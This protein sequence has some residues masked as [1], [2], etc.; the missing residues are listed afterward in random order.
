L[1][2]LSQI[3][4]VASAL[5]VFTFFVTMG[6]VLYLLGGTSIGQDLA[7]HSAK[8][9][10][11]AFL[12]LLVTPIRVNALGA[13]IVLFAIYI[14]C[15][16]IAFRSNPGFFKSIRNM[17]GAPTKDPPNW[18]I[19]MPLAASALLLVVVAL[20]I[21][22]D[23]LGVPSGSLPNLAPYELLYD[24]AYA[25]PAEETAFRITTLGLLVTFMVLLTNPLKRVATGTKPPTTRRL[26]L[27]GLLFPE[28]A[29]GEAGLSTVRANGLRGLNTIEW[30]ALIV[31]SVG[32]GIAHYT[33]DVGWQ[34][35]KVATA[36]LSGFALGLAF[37]AYGAYA[38]ILLHWFFDL[39][40]GTY[41]V[42]QMLNAGAFDAAT[43]LLIL[44]I[45]AVGVIGII[46]AIAHFV[47]KTSPTSQT[48]YI[49][50]GPLPPV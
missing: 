24:L 41:S 50:P 25:A 14:G 28:K 9:H 46:G 37:L 16:V 6:I 11:G 15:F 26:V 27:L 43:A 35:G 1:G 3:E 29:K 2:I 49:I 13:F 10:I 31:T 19:I 18:L 47:R 20:T 8:L 45:I 36:A 5:T 7:G 12:I 21:I 38:S 17:F 4:A 39:Y 48:S 30:L 40:L 33:A 23:A 22:Q 34:A 32:F 42:G 44:L